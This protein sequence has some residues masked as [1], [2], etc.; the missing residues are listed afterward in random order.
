M[1]VYKHRPPPRPPVCL[2]LLPS[3]REHFSLTFPDLAS[4]VVQLLSCSWLFCD[5]ARLPSPW[6]FPG[7]NT[8]VGCHFLLEEIFLSQGSGSHKPTSCVF[9]AGRQVLYNWATREVLASIT[10]GQ[11]L[12]FWVSRD[13]GFHILG[14]CW[15]SSAPFL[16]KHFHNPVSLLNRFHWI[17]TSTCHL[18]FLPLATSVSCPIWESSATCGYYV[19]EMGLVQIQP[20]SSDKTHNRFPRLSTKEAKVAC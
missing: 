13:A 15:L 10:Y 19:L 18:S 17:C 2:L 1:G 14:W 3:W 9:C 11:T 12:F 8:G 16:V 20:S 7:K 6:N 5:P 4:I